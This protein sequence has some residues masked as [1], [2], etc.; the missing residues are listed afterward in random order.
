MRKGASER[1]CPGTGGMR[2]AGEEARRGFVQTLGVR[3]GGDRP[4]EVSKLKNRR[5]GNRQG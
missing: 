4:P 2:G 5:I 3:D 1:G